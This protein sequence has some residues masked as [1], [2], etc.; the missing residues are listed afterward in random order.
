MIVFSFCFIFY[1]FIVICLCLMH[2]DFFQLPC[3]LEWLGEESHA[4]QHIAFQMLSTDFF[5]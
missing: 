2:S 4:G 1:V 3:A 5:V